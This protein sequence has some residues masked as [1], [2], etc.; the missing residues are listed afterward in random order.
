METAPQPEKVAPK[1]KAISEPYQ[2]LV[3]DL[4]KKFRERPDQPKYSYADQHLLAEKSS[5][6]QAAYLSE[7]TEENRIAAEAAKD[8]FL[9]SKSDKK[10]ISTVWT[11]LAAAKYYLESEEAEII[12]KEK[13]EEMMGKIENIYVDLDM[14]RDKQNIDDELIEKVLKVM[15]EIETNLNK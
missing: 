1:E 8:E 6:A 12:P 13:M 14:A 4:F 2:K 10:H 3:R 9:E 15:E 7:K 5:A 11:P